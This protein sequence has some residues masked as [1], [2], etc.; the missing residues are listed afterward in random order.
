MRVWNVE[1]AQVYATLRAIKRTSVEWFL[2]A[3][4]DYSL[5]IHISHVTPI[6]VCLNNRSP[7]VRFFEMKTTYCLG[8]GW[9]SLLALC[10]LLLTEQRT[11]AGPRFVVIPSA[12]E[13]AEGNAIVGFGSSVAGWGND[14][15]SI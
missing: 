9:F 14:G 6:K 8:A 15:A 10:V 7:S 13:I 3:T 4:G 12:A 5:T 1:D 11:Q 2:P